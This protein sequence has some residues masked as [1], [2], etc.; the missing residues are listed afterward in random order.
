MLHCV[1]T[2]LGITVFVAVAACF[3]LPYGWTWLR[4]KSDCKKIDMIPGPKT[5]PLIGNLLLFHV[6]EE[7]KSALGSSQSDHKI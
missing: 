2:A 5:F 6:P 7:S 4:R 3:V 1:L